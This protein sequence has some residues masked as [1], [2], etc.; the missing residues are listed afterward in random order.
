MQ[1]HNY[2]EIAAFN[3]RGGDAQSDAEY[4]H[5]EGVILTDDVSVFSS[6]VVSI[7]QQVCSQDAGTFP[8]AT[9]QL[10]FAIVLS[11]LVYFVGNI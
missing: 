9:T 5:K 3:L 1:R 10:C 6:I 8:P 2:P 11:L 4:S 7:H